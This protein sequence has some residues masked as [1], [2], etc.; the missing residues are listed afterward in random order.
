M[1]RGGMVSGNKE[2]GRGEIGIHESLKEEKKRVTG[3]Q[4]LVFFP[5]K[6]FKIR[7]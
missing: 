5:E 7:E 1:R 2:G 3:N 4:F 6:K